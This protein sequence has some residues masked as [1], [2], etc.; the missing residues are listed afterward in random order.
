ML[1]NFVCENVVKYDERCW[2]S[3]LN[4]VNNEHL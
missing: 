3:F 1:V 4:M 2:K